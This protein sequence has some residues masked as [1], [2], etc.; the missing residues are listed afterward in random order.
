M[1][2]CFQTVMCFAV[3]HSTGLS[4]LFKFTC[5]KGNIVYSALLKIML[6]LN[7]NKQL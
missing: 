4:S 1:N 6:Y 5:T 2:P 3:S 7:M